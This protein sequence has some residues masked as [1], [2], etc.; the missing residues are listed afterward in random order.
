MRC[1]C[2]MMSP[3]SSI[4]ARISHHLPKCQKKKRSSLMRSLVIWSRRLRLLA[5]CATKSWPCQLRK[6]GRPRIRRQHHHLLEHLLHPH[7][8]CPVQDTGSSRCD[9]NLPAQPSLISSLL[10]SCWDTMRV[11][12]PGVILHTDTGQ[13][14][15]SLGVK[16]FVLG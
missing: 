2:P 9:E 7:Q 8:R 12:L 10:P 3:S 14:P 4:H 11:V 13:S 15:T 16:S 6:K 1:P 5:L